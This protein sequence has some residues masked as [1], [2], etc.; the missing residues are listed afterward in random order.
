MVSMLFSLDLVLIIDG[1]IVPALHLLLLML[2]FFLSFL[3]SHLSYILIL[4][5][6]LRSCQRPCRLYFLYDLFLDL[7]RFFVCLPG[8]LRGFGRGTKL[9][10]LRLAITQTTPLQTHPCPLVL[11]CVVDRLSYHSHVALDL[12]HRSYTCIIVL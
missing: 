7:F 2:L 10:N 3:H 6:F 8:R 4:L 9:V 12:C 5:P 1:T 11:L